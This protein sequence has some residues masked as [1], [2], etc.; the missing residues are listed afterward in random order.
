MKLLF[1]GSLARGL[2]ASIVGRARAAS[3]AAAERR[4][5]PSSRPASG[6][7]AWTCADYGDG[8]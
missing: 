5:V 3:G 2:P 6:A 4:G 8:A 7:V 1:D